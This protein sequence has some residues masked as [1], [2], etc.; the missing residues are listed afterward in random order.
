MIVQSYYRKWKEEMKCNK[1]GSNK[2]ASIGRKHLGC[3]FWDVT[4][5]CPECGHTQKESY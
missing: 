3:D 5:K 4:F 2:T 1:C